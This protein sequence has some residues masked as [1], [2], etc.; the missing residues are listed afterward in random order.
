MIETWK[1]ALDEQKYAGAILT[2]LT[3]AFDCLNHDLL[4]V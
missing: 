4:L 1:K 2:D 3:K